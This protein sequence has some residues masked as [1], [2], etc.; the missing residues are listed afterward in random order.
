M[1]V[2]FQVAGQTNLRLQPSF[3]FAMA[4]TS[5]NAQAVDWIDIRSARPAC[6]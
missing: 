6:E 4:I 1:H 2:S 5:G 3:L